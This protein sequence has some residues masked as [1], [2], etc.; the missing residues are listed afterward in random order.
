MSVSVI[1]STFNAP[2]WLEKVI[3]GHVKP[4]EIFQLSLR[5]MDP[6]RKQNGLLKI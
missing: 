4:I 1:I 6:D 5:T 3:V 2:E